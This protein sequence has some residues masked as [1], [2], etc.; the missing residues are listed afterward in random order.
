MSSKQVNN[1]ATYVLAAFIKMMGM[2]V[3]TI[4]DMHVPTSFHYLSPIILV[5]RNAIPVSR[6]L[7]RQCHGALSLS[8]RHAIFKC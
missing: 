7:Y 8:K 5:L 1:P 6:A 2:H 3:P 4:Q